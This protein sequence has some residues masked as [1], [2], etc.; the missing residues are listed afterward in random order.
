MPFLEYKT[1]HPLHGAPVEAIVGMIIAGN[2][3]AVGGDLGRIN[4]LAAPHAGENVYAPL[5]Q[6]R[7]QAA[8]FP[9]AALAAEAL[10]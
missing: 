10:D 5:R 7:G 8:Q 1:A 4:R 3:R 6:N 9:L 2:P